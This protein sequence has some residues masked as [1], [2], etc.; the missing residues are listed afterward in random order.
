[1]GGIKEGAEQVTPRFSSTEHSTRVSLRG[2]GTRSLGR[3]KRYT[4][5]YSQDIGEGYGLV[6]KG[7]WDGS[8]GTLR[9]RGNCG[10]DKVV[11]VFGRMR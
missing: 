10:R 3:K 1:M 4:L 7:V 6:E 2:L 8:C 9:G 5:L 11:A